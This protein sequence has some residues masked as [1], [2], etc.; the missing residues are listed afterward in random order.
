[1]RPNSLFHFF[2]PS[3]DTF[4]K[5]QCGISPS[6]FNAAFRQLTDDMAT[7][8][9]ISERSLSKTKTPFTP[10]LFKSLLSTNAL[11]SK[12]NRSLIGLFVFKTK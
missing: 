11:S 1:M 8:K 5:S 7:F 6:T 12:S 10:L 3:L 2:N 4:S 9:E